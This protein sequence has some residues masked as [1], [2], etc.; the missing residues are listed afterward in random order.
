[1][2]HELKR[3]C[4]SVCP[5]MCMQRL[6]L[7]HVLSYGTKV[8]TKQRNGGSEVQ[9]AAEV[10]VVGQRGQNS[11]VDVAGSTQGANCNFE[12]TGRNGG[13]EVQGAA[14][15]V[16]V[17]QRRQNSG[18]DVAGS[19]QGANCNFESTGRVHARGIWRKLTGAWCCFG[20][21]EQWP[22]RRRRFGWPAAR[23][24]TPTMCSTDWS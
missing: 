2:E 24:V 1:M 12:S 7:V 10:V 15:V 6:G 18:V 4:V 23:T 11:G 22:E 17:G 5:C 21:E 19:T 13:S 9:G 20:G 3:R 16:V 14:E 8:L